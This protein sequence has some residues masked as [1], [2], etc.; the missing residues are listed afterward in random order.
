M[1]TERF[2]FTGEGGHQLAAALELPDGEPRAY[3][4]FAHCF[5][6]GKDALAAKRICGRAGRQGHR[7][8]ALRFH[9]ARLQRRRIRQYDLLVERRRSRAAPPIICAT[10]GPGD[11]DRPQPRRRGGAGGR[12]ADLR[13]RAVVTIAAPSDPAHVTGIF[14]E[15]H[16]TD[17]RARRGRGLARGPPVQHQARVPRRRRRTQ[18]DDGYRR[19]AQGPAGDALTARRHRRH[20]QCDEDLRGGKASQELRLAGQAP[21]TC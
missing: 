1:P 8:A 13:M 7:G 21:I 16:M 3:A 9:R 2:Q 15:T 18:P 10:A 20:R 12:R 6:C 4:L 14:S 5:T 19:A 11:P 17:P